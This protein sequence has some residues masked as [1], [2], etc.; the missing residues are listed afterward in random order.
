[1]IS[2]TLLVDGETEPAPPAGLLVDLMWAHATAVDRLEHVR[3][4]TSTS[5]IDIVFF[6]DA[7]GD[8]APGRNEAVRTADRVC[9]QAIAASAVLNG[10][11]LQ[12]EL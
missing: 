12:P 9:R 7:P 2:R 10:W 11:Y 1:M 3:A 4:V 5:R 8:G 6:I